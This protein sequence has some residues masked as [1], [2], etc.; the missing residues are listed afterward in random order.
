MRLVK[1]YKDF[2]IS[3]HG[4]IDNSTV[5]CQQVWCIFRT[6][7]LMTPQVRQSYGGFVNIYETL[8]KFGKSIRRFRSFFVLYSLCHFE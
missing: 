4:F 5:N 6:K 8:I 7:S 2:S 1:Y 3:I